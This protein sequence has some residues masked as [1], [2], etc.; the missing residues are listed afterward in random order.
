MLARFF[1]AIAFCRVA[2]STRS[3]EA[4]FADFERADSQSCI[5][6]PEYIPHSG[7]PPFG[8]YVRAMARFESRNNLLGILYCEDGTFEFVASDPGIVS[9]D[10]TVYRTGRWWWEG[11][12]SCT[13]IDAADSDVE[14]PPARCKGEGHWLGDHKVVIPRNASKVAPSKK[15]A[16]SA[17]R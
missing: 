12:K 1:F 11:S 10:T 2:F 17:R 13:Q 7:D 16:V 8:V 6:P 15:S 9:L 14:V 5:P 3:E 4:R